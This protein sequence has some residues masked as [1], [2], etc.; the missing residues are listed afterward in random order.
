MN[1][2]E[3]P[4]KKVDGNNRPY[5]IPGQTDR[6]CEDIHNAN[7]QHL[8]YGVYMGRKHDTAFKDYGYRKRRRI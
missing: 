7:V 6:L 5:H 3:V 1:D 2:Y 8:S 4:E